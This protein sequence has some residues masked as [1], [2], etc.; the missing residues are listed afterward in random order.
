MSGE[1]MK[2]LSAQIGEKLAPAYNKLLDTGGKILDFFNKLSDGQ[3]KALLIGVAVI[4]AL[5]P[6]IMVIGNLIT[7]VKA[8]NVAFMFLA[9]NPIVLAITAIILVIAGLA[10]L[11]IKNWDTIKAFFINLWNTVKKAVS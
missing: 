3:Q 4:A 1:R 5:G 10:F 11:I 6:L 8:L 2:E 9:A 7:V